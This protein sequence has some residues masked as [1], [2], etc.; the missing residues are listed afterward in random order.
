MDFLLLISLMSISNMLSSEFY[1]SKSQLMILSATAKNWW[2]YYSCSNSG[3][4]FSHHFKNVHLLYNFVIWFSSFR[5]KLKTQIGLTL[6]N[7]FTKMFRCFTWSVSKLGQVGKS[8]NSTDK[9]F[10]SWPQSNHKWQVHDIHSSHMKNFSTNH[11]LVLV[12]WLYCWSLEIFTLFTDM[13][14]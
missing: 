7:C 8:V 1:S 10:D 12:T 6:Y 3:P 4:L 13:K 9:M 5:L 14:T 11:Q 2:I